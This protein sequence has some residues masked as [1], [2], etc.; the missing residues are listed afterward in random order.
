MF[1]SVVVCLRRNLHLVHLMDLLW[2]DIGPSEEV[3]WRTVD[4]CSGF[5]ISSELR[6]A[7]PGYVALPDNDPQFVENEFGAWLRF[8]DQQNCEAA[9]WLRN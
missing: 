5:E 4:S 8:A 1:S 2:I 9:G 6:Y 3:S 7:K